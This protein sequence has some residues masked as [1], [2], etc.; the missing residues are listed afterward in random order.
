M[1]N[2]SAIK[3]FSVRSKTYAVQYAT[4][5]AVVLGQ[6][7]IGF[8]PTQTIQIWQD[9]VVDTVVFRV[10][11][12]SATDVWWAPLY[13][14]D[15]VN[16]EMVLI[17]YWEVVPSVIGN[18]SVTKSTPITLSQGTYF[19]GTACKDGTGQCLRINNTFSASAPKCPFFNPK[20]HP[21]YQVR[22]GVSYFVIDKPSGIWTS[23]S[24]FPT[25]FPFASM[26]TAASSYPAVPWN[27][28]L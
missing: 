5:G 14:A 19:L 8:Y 16:K 12:Q 17:D 26:R 7:Y 22:D 27:L 15:P 21:G 9:T 2:V 6:T 1:D 20:T 28:V 25:T 24:E 10:R 3:G 13:K 18:I 23:P 4:Y 11:S